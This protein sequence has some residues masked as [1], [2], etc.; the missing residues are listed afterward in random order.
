MK[1][2]KSNGIEKAGNAG[3]KLQAIFSN[4]NLAEKSEKINASL[5][6]AKSVGNK[7][8][9]K[10]EYLL[11]L[12]PSDKKARRMAR[13]AQFAHSKRVISDYQTKSK[14]LIESLNALNTFYK[15]ALIDFNNFS[16]IDADKEKGKIITLAHE[17]LKGSL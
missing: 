6:T 8:F 13:N 16:Q 14:S 1:N 15:D 12:S 9:W 17:I 7:S 11:S 3:D 4:A 10:K 5:L 2:S